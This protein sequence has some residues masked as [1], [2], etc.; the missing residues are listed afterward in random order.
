MVHWAAS[1]ETFLSSFTSSKRFSFSTILLMLLL[2]LLKV[3]SQWVASC[4]R[5]IFFLHLKSMHEGCFNYSTFNWN[6]TTILSTAMVIWFY[7]SCEGGEYWITMSHIVLDRQNAH[8]QMWLLHSFQELDGLPETE[9]ISADSLI[10][11]NGCCK[12]QEDKYASAVD[13]SCFIPTQGLK[14]LQRKC[15]WHTASKW[16]YVATIF[17]CWR[18][19]TTMGLKAF[20]E[21]KNWRHMN[22]TLHIIHGIGY[23]LCA[24]HCWNDERKVAPVENISISAKF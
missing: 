12:P 20:C 8:L 19:I 15:S 3:K 10:F 16:F 1:C 17:Y 2:L 4:C 23:F 21:V 13:P 6:Q 9:P 5:P 11:W 24:G 14:L 22:L 7:C 18:Q